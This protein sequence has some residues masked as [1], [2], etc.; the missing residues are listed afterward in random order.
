M[1]SEYIQK[2]IDSANPQKIKELIDLVKELISEMKEPHYEKYCEIENKL[3]EISEGKVLNEEKA[4]H[5]IDS[6]KPYGMK[7]SMDETEQVRT[8]YGYTDIRPVDFWIVMNS[9]YND[10]KDLFNDEIDKYAMFSYAFINDEDA[11]EDKV[12]NYFTKI[13]K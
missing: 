13:V 9:A 1:H 7:W 2:I 6:M 3:Y 10:Y 11:G 5:I 4:K 12:Y 8:N